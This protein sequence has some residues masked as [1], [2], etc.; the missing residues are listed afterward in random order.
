MKKKTLVL[1]LGCLITVSALVTVAY[2]VREANTRSTITFGNL[3]LKPHLYT[4]EGGSMIEV[5][6]NETVSISGIPSLSRILNIENV[7]NHPMYVRVNFET[8]LVDNESE[9]IDNIIYVNEKDDWIQSGGYYYYD[10]TLA[11]GEKTT[12]LMDEILFD[13]AS[14][15]TNYRGSSIDYRI[16]I[17]A[18]QSEHNE[19]NVLNAKGWPET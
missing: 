18:I 9:L 16:N 19:D 1:I 17:E 13:T 3:A 5:D 15:D 8:F 10:T 6:P 12:D 2:I 7:G 14:I 4:L 11:P